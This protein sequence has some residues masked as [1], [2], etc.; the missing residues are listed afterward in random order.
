M[1]VDIFN[2]HINII[3]CAEHLTVFFLNFRSPSCAWLFQSS[4]PTMTIFVSNVNI[5]CTIARVAFFDGIFSLNPKNRFLNL[6]L[7][8]LTNY[9]NRTK[10]T[11]MYAL[12]ICVLVFRTYS[13][14]AWQK[15]SKVSMSMRKS[16]LLKSLTKKIVYY[17]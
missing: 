3:Y 7:T 12:V 2:S 11:S 13:K 10:T 9:L 1:H 4:D 16:S 8:G 15:A 17:S 6:I 5:D 14:L